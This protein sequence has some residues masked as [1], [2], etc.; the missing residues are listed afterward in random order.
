[1]LD[2]YVLGQRVY[3]QAETNLA[4]RLEAKVTGTKYT[5]P[6][7]LATKIF[8]W[9]DSLQKINQQ[10]THSVFPM[11]YLGYYFHSCVVQ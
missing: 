3:H 9:L 6:P 10:S 2:L 8:I 4:H 5:F 11:R 7:P 1:M